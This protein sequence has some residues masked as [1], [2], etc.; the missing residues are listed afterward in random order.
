MLRKIIRNNFLSLAGIFKAPSA[1][2][3]IMN[4]HYVSRNNLGQEVFYDLLE[5]LNKRLKFIRIEE[6]TELVTQKKLTKEKLIAFTFD[7]GFSE[8]YT[9][10]APVLEEF[11]TNAAFFINPG[12]V[13]G[14]QEYI[15][16]FQEKKVFTIGKSPMSWKQILEL[17]QRGH[18]IGSHTVDHIRLNTED[19][20]ELTF[21]I[22]KCK[23]IIQYKT[24]AP[25]EYFAYPYGQLSDIN[26]KALSIAAENH[27]YIFSGANYKKYFSFHGKVLNRRHF[28]GDWPASHLNYFLSIQRSYDQGRN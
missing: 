12:F 1:G 20:A 18:I 15:K 4:G 8:C 16:T 14:N 7:D 22:T 24:G 9:K 2:I 21:Q 26:E 27:K 19:Q 11:K 17:H 6:A 25:C 23:E 13:E 3:H 28:E 10:I 5:Q